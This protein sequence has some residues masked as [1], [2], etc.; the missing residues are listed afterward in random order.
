MG[1][2]PTFAVTP[3]ANLNSPRGG[4]CGSR[5]VHSVTGEASEG[6]A[7][8]TM[9]SSQRGHVLL[10]SSWSAAETA[11]S[12]LPSLLGDACSGGPVRGCSVALCS[13]P[14]A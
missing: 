7:R 9:A 3:A 14:D 6:S 13:S 8:P 5:D 4:R 1:C 11:L 2:I 12:P 10:L